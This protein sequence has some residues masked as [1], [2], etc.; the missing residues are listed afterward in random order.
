MCADHW[1]IEC[2]KFFD[3]AAV[4]FDSTIVQ[5]MQY[6]PND[7]FSYKLPKN[8]SAMPLYGSVATWLFV[9]THLT[10]RLYTFYFSDLLLVASSIFHFSVFT[11][12]GEVSVHPLTRRWVLHGY[13]F[14]IIRSQSLSASNLPSPILY[15]YAVMKRIEIISLWFQFNIFFCIIHCLYIEQLPLFFEK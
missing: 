7:A 5:A 1:R 3:T 14:P 13:N 4:H 11:T 9:Y 12:F 6:E 15:C 10:L 8:V 2:A